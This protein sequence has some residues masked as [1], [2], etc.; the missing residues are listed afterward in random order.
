MHCI[1]L[2]LFD[3][4]KLAALSHQIQSVSI[5][6]WILISRF[7]FH[8]F[9]IPHFYYTNCTNISRYIQTSYTLSQPASRTSECWS[10]CLL[11]A[12]TMI[13]QRLSM[14]L[15][16]F[17]LIVFVIYIFYLVLISVRSAPHT[18]I[19]ILLLIFIFAPFMMVIEL[20]RPVNASHAFHV[21]RSIWYVLF[22]CFFHCFVVLTYLNC[23]YLSRYCLLW[24]L[25]LLFCCYLVL[26]CFHFG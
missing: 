22:F 10:D 18:C 11:R 3:P 12:A 25:L 8:S 23:F 14:K 21:L 2:S 9:I 5:P 6:I 24:L 19:H 16:V 13:K 1:D 17:N 7:D 26:F 4:M 20:A 15:Y